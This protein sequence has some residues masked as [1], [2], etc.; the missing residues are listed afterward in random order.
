MCSSKKLIISEQ[1]NNNNNK[2]KIC[3]WHMYLAIKIQKSLPESELYLRNK[4]M[5]QILW[6]TK[7]MLC[8]A[9]LW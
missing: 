5:Q 2:K 6:F 1:N 9:S 8:N 7:N 4:E 3:F